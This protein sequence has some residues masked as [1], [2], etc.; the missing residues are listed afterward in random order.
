[1]TLC[2]GLAEAGLGG[3]SH[4]PKA[5]LKL[6]ALDCLTGPDG[7]AWAGSAVMPALPII[8]TESISALISLQTSNNVCT[9]L[10][11]IMMANAVS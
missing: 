4:P 5:A 3:A 11:R 1:M 2:V 6:I 8:A 7:A 10:R 9:Q